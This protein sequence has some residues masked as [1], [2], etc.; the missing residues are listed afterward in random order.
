MAGIR[1]ALVTSAPPVTLRNHYAKCPPSSD[2]SPTASASTK[3]HGGEKR[4][5]GRIGP[6]PR[7][8][9]DQ[10]SAEMPQ[11]LRYGRGTVEADP[12]VLHIHVDDRLTKRISKQ[13]A[14]GVYA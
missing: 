8:S 5:S 7:H 4:I 12:V 2:F 14:C 13:L 6:E 11:L 10:A 9:L 3:A 1:L